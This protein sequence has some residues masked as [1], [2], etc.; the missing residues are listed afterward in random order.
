M[1]EGKPVVLDRAELNENSST[2]DPVRPNAANGTNVSSEASRGNGA[3]V[4]MNEVV[5]NYFES[6]CVHINDNYI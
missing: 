6:V 3:T 5:F 1:A 2:D 4:G